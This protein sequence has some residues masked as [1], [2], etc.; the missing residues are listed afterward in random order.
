MRL[1][2]QEPAVA[3]PS[4]VPRIRTNQLVIIVE[5]GMVVASVTA[6]PCMVAAP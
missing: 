1:P 5:M 4:A 2:R 6:M 3:M